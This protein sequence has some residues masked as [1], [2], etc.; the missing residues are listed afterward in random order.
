MLYRIPDYFYDFSCMADQCEDTC[1]AGW[2]IM[3][4]EKS[5]KRYKKEEGGYSKTLH[6]QIDWQEECFC[7]KEERRCAFLRQDNLCDMYVHLGEDSL[8][9]T[10]R[11]YP[12][13]VEEFENVRE[14]HLS[15]SCPVAAELI[16]SRKSPVIYKESREKNGLRTEDDLLENE[17]F[18]DY[19]SELFHRLIE[20]RNIM[21][22]IVQNRS[23]TY[24]VRAYLVLLLAFQFQKRWENE[25][26]ESFL[27]VITKVQTDSFQKQV[28]NNL[29]QLVSGNEEWFVLQ[30]KIFEEIY[31]LERLEAGWEMLLLEVRETLYSGSTGDY[32]EKVREFSQWCKDNMPDWD[33]WKEQLLIYFLHTYFCG[34]VYDEAIYAQAQM[35]VLSVFFVEK[36]LCVCFYR[37]EKSLSWQEIMEIVYRF[38]REIEH[39]QENLDELEEI[40]EQFPVE[41]CKLLK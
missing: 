41:V 9:D 17:E 34:A 33:I 30:K 20:A 28:E 2:Q 22:K 27:S 21:D 36:I 18:E 24:E 14:W 29:N 6:E 1:C 38:S 4:D 13:H 3:I 26:D 5:L 8:C 39:S 35:A 11:L 31:Y 37:N 15:V 19:D 32:E 7:Q 12:R 10:C 40:M 16:L 23:V 25:D